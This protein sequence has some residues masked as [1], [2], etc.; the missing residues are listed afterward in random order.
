[1]LNIKQ[2]ILCAAVVKTSTVSAWNACYGCLIN[3]MTVAII[4]RQ[5]VFIN[6]SSL[7]T[8]VAPWQDYG[9]HSTCD[10][11]NDLHRISNDNIIIHNLY[12]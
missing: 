1:M 5:H 6:I 8:E 11:A 2:H 12:T 10:G 3:V 9:S 4:D 7:T